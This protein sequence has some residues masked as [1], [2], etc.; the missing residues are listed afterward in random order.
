MIWVVA[1]LY[2]LVGCGVVGWMN[3]SEDDNIAG[4]EPLIALIWPC[5]L[6]VIAGSWVA[7]KLS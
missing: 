2:I 5:V 7:R 1:L 3:E 6:A 4:V